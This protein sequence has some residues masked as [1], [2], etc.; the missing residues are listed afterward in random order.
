M[1]KILTKITIVNNIDEV[2]FERNIIKLNEVR[3]L[4]INDVLIDTGATTLALPAKI[5]NQL[6]LK[7]M[8]SVAVSTASGISERKIYQNVKVRLLE[9]ETIC[10]CIE[11]PDDA[12][13]LLGVIPLE[14]MGVELNL[15]TQ[16][17]KFLPY[18]LLSTYITVF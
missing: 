3:S 18:D 11:L 14:S 7:Y 12:M 5:I 6:G 13:P 10:E 4:Q 9:R 8:K 2:L 16:S 15:Q 1:G 17:L